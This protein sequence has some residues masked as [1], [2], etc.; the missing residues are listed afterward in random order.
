MSMG[1]R[2]M[3]KT[4]KS[5]TISVKPEMFEHLNELA[6]KHKVSRSEVVKTILAIATKEKPVMQK[7]LDLL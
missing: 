2:N 1:K 5:F 6:K 3:I 4:M 7:A